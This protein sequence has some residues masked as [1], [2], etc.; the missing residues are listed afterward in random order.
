MSSSRVER[1]I[2]VAILGGGW[3]GTRL[4]AYLKAD[5]EPFEVVAITRRE[6]HPPPHTVFR[7]DDASTWSACDGA[8]AIVI[9]FKLTVPVSVLQSFVNYISQKTGTKFPVS[10]AT[11]LQA[12]MWSMRMVLL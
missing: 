9:T 3:V 2:K 4:A 11:P 12:Y 6:E 10:S 7:L 5:S 8:N 1:D